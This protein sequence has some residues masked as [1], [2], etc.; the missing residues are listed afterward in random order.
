MYQFS[1]KNR[2]ALEQ[3][4]LPLAIFQNVD[5]KN[6]PVLVT[7]GFCT[8]LG[9]QRD[10]VMKEQKSSKFD[11]IHPEDVGRIAQAV[12]E[13][14][15]KQSN[16]D[17]IYRVRQADNEYHYV[18]SIA[19]WW[20]M[21]EV[22]EL[23]VVIYL[24]LHKWGNEIRKSSNRY[25]LFQQDHF[26][27]DP[28][29]G[30]PNINYLNQFADERVNTLRIHEKTPVLIYTDVQAM[31]FYN[32]HYGF[33]RGNELMCLIAEELKAAF[34]EGLVARGA[35]DHFVV[36]DAFTDRETLRAKIRE[37]NDRIRK[38]A[39]GNTS[40]IQAGIS[41][42]EKEA[43]TAETIDQAKQAVKK[44]REDLNRVVNYYSHDDNESYWN[45]RYIIENFEK[46]ME[47]GWIKVFYQCVSRVETGKVASLEALARWIDPVR[48]TISP[49]VFIPVLGRFHQLHKLDLYM[50]EQV[51]KEIRIRAENGF[52]IVPVSMNF[53]AQDFDYVD[54]PAALN[55][56]YD[57]YGISRYA[58]KGCFV[59]E[60]T[61]QDVAS[62]TDRFREQLT[63]LK[64]DGYKLWLDDFGSGYSSLSMFSR[65]DFNMIKFDM[66]L[67]RHLDEHN[68]ANR[69]IIK[70]MTEVARELGIHTLAEGMETEEQQQFLVEC[71][72]ELAQGYLYHKPEPLESFV[73]KAK[74][75]HPHRTCETPEER[76]ENMKKWLEKAQNPR[77]D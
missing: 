38:K 54:I 26:Y 21:D 76:I 17:V 9:V 70:A 36:I 61:E 64:N 34:P 12:T 1:D 73:Y 74:T 19:F 42:Y 60:I 20:P 30:L 62:A 46:A 48:G 47:E 28:L 58:G 24:D 33:S 7:E 6:V 32:N 67:L 50:A 3:L 43:K 2:K 51:C 56:L 44:I 68:G 23:I 72:C 35:E 40:G 14:W 4:A 66:D 41:L 69:R 75:G 52:P 65:F 31:Q 37:A 55:E 53:T 39:Y 29:T 57:R 71:G 77:F 22:T 13:F 18:H 49:G 10:R 16:Y 15:S 11:R 59:I 27:T 25:G 63:T 5:G 8:L 45:Q